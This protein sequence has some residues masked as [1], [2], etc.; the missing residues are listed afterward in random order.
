MAVWQALL[1]R[2]TLLTVFSRD[3]QC[4]GRC[5]PLALLVGGLEVTDIRRPSRHRLP[6]DNEP[7]GG[8]LETEEP[9]LVPC[10]LDV[11]DAG[12]LLELRLPSELRGGREEPS[13]H[14]LPGGIPGGP[15][16]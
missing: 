15:A 10:R 4:L 9:L 13:D 11:D 16:S 5:E 2:P 14:D 3:I 1:I 8:S 7:I 6:R 12:R